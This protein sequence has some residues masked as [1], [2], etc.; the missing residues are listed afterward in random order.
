MGKPRNKTSPGKEKTS[1]LG[2]VGAKEQMQEIV[3]GLW[4][5]NVQAAEDEQNLHNK[6]ISHIL[7]VFSKYLPDSNSAGKPRYH[8]LILPLH[9]NHTELLI[10]HFP[11][12]NEFIRQALDSKGKVL[13]HCKQGI[14]RSATVVLAFLLRYGFAASVAEA[15]DLVRQKR[16]YINPNFGFVEQL[17]VYHA[18]AFRPTDQAVWLYCRLRSR[19]AMFEPTKYSLRGKLDAVEAPILTAHPKEI[20]YTKTTAT[21]SLRC[22]KCN[23]PLAPPEIV[24][25]RCPNAKDKCSS[26]FLAQPMDWMASEMEKRTFGMTLICCPGCQEVVGDYDWHG[27]ECDCRH[28]YLPGIRLFVAKLNRDS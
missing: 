21:N 3:P 18:C 7:S 22:A 14:S 10:E 15:F 4:L 23:E 11:T 28:W 20:P 8:R 27:L 12:T 26:Y 13:V 5:G 1:S 16:H 24:L 17:L 9:D 2:V 6:K 19:C 25:P